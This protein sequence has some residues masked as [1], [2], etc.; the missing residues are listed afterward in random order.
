MNQIEKNVTNS[1]RLAKSDII[2]LQNDFLKLSQTQERIMEM[3]DALDINQVK[4]NQKVKEKTK[5]KTVVI[6][7]NGRTK[8]D[9]ISTK[10]GKKFHITSC[11]FAQNI[12]PKNRVKFK[13][14]TK[15]L[16]QGY[17]PCKCVK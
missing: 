6:N 8:K 3:I 13:S 14:K 2:R 12:K 5:P 16:N 1:F 10:D 11:P 7:K 9:Y 15:A 4:I 17:K